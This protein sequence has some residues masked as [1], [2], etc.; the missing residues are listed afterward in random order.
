MNE[1]SPETQP[2]EATIVCIGCTQI[3]RESASFCP[4]CGA[5]VGD[6]AWVDPLKRILAGGYVNRRF[7]SGRPRK[8]VMVVE[9]VLG[10]VMIPILV[11][12]VIRADSIVDTVGML[13]WLALSVAFYYRLIKNFRHVYGNKECPKGSKLSDEGA[14]PSPET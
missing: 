12:F 14:V 9:I 7:T 4:H 1:T 13:L 2:S 11:A 8:W 3:I 5:P 6:T 10:I